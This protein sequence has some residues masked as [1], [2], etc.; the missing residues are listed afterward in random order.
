[1]C[2]QYFKQQ[3][4]AGAQPLDSAQ[5][6]ATLPIIPTK[7]LQTLS[8]G[9]L[10]H[11]IIVD[12]T[13][14]PCLLLMSLAVSLRD[15]IWAQIP[16]VKSPLKV[17]LPVVICVGTVTCEREAAVNNYF[18]QLLQE[19]RQVNV[20]VN[21][22]R[23]Q[24]ALEERDERPHRMVLDHI[25]SETAAHIRHL[26]STADANHKHQSSLVR[27]STEVLVSQ[28][29]SENQSFQRAAAAEHRMVRNL[30][31]QLARR[32]AEC[33]EERRMA[34]NSLHRTSNSRHVHAHF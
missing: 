12:F 16:R 22:R 17:D 30:Q 11:A 33:Q 7:S 8:G 27:E 4:P 32:D 10:F 6:Y 34:C 9:H 14:P 24:E 26:E 28:H 20:F 25:Y 23:V 13:L 3:A 19:N 15:Y 29:N 18:P 1:M 21:D 31:E 5:Q 2:Y